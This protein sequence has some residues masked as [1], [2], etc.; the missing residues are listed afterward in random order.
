LILQIFLGMAIGKLLR[1]VMFIDVDLQALVCAAIAVP[2]CT[3]IPLFIV[4]SMVNKKRVLLFSNLIDC[5]CQLMSENGALYQ[6]K[7]SSKSRAYVMF[8]TVS[9]D[10][11]IWAVLFTY[12]K[13]KHVAD[14]DEPQLANANDSD[15]ESCASSED[16]AALCSSN[17]GLRQRRSGSEGRR[18][19]NRNDTEEAAL[20]HVLLAVVDEEP[21]KDEGFYTYAYCCC[22]CVES[23]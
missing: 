13:L 17:E 21:P 22:C 5:V 2:N 3:A 19:R 16:A 11:F 12:M 15:F 23:E 8:G 9:A 18:R 14:D 6:L 10:L 4:N 20:S 1:R 7:N